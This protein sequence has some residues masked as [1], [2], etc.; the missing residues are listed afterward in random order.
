MICAKKNTGMHEGIL[1]SGIGAVEARRK[2]K[3]K[4]PLALNNIELNMKMTEFQN[5]CG[6]SWVL[7]AGGEYWFCFEGL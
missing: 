2:A 6:V 3:K 1:V 5:K 7:H 4:L